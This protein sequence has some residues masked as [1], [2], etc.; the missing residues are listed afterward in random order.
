MENSL[1]CPADVSKNAHEKKTM[2][3]VVAVVKVTTETGAMC[4]QLAPLADSNATT[5][6]VNQTTSTLTSSDMLFT[7]S[8]V[9]VVERKGSPLHFHQELQ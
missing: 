6:L 2:P 3:I 5:T 1:F 7:M 8:L 4:F 9:S